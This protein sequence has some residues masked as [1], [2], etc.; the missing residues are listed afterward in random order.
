MMSILIH[1]TCIAY[2]GAGLLLRGPSGSGKSDLALRALD[3]GWDLVS[4]DQTVINREEERLIASPPTTIAG[5]LEVR[6]LGLVHYPFVPRIELKMVVDLVARA[7]IERLP[8][9]ASLEVL[10]RPLP[11]TQLFPFESSALAKLRLALGLAT[12]DTRLSS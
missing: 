4:D 8:D 1:A 5:L 9:L 3:A 7:R 6:G 10:G 11:L 2:Q 12:G